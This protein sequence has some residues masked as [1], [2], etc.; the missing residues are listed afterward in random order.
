MRGHVAYVG[1]KKR[2]TEF[3]SKSQKGYLGVGERIILKKILKGF[4]LFR[5]GSSV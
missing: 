2:H 4:F 5:I 3:L 1:D